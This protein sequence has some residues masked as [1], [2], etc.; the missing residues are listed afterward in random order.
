[1]K[2]FARFSSLLGAAAMLFGFAS[3]GNKSAQAADAAADSIS[4]E[5]ENTAA[6][7]EATDSLAAIFLNPGK[8]SDVATDSTYAVTESGLKYMVMREG[9][10]ISP[11]ATDQV[12]VHYEGRLPNGTVFDSSYSRGEPTS[13]PLNRVIPGW[14]EGLQL[15]K[16]GGM[17]VFYIPSDLA[18]GPQ[19]TPGG[20]IGPN[21][22]L[23][24]T[25]ELIK[26]N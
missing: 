1:M 15:M 20:P 25:V 3:C 7:P 13:F 23:L 6:A 14:T 10:G 2:K 18:Y 21:Q 11:K 19:G 24:F 17:A 26:V 4:E 5:I 9:N 12:T 22:D 8:K 16:E